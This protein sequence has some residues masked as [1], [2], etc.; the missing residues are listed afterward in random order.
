MIDWANSKDLEAML[1]SLPDGQFQ[2]ELRVFAVNCAERVLR[3]LHEP[4]FSSVLNMSWRFANGTCTYDE[5]QQHVSAASA[6]LDP[7]TDVPTTRDLAGSAVVDASTV[8][9]S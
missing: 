8:H 1:M 7:N 9:P 3:F 5:L 6:L 2:S 4:E